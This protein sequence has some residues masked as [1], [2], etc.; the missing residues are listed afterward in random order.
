MWTIGAVSAFNSNNQTLMSFQVDT[1]L[2]NSYRANIEI[3]FQQKG[4]RLR[5][6]VRVESQNSEFDFFDRIGPT[7]AV[8]VKNRHSDTPLISTPHDRRRNATEDY[9]WA[10]LI[11]RKD[12]IRMLA[13]PTSSYV[14][15]AVM[16]LGRS[17]DIEIARAAF[18]TAYTG[19][20]GSTSVSFPATQDVAVNF[21]DITGS[22]NTNLTLSKLR[23]TRLLFDLEEAVD[24]DA[25]E[26]LYMAVTAWQINSMLREDKATSADYAAIKALVRGEIET[27][28]GIKFIRVHPTVLTKSG[29]VRQC[30]VWTRQGLLLGIA[31]DVMVD[32]GPRRDK[33]NSVQAYVCASFGA[34]RMWEE[35]VVRVYCDETK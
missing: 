11:D 12:K 7:A 17:M 28:M 10:D 2:V 34:T 32:V 22:G 29:D 25:A 9:D 33:R 14:T 35:Q 6:Y 23:K 18:A 4:S 20:T 1:A 19:K 8:K 26:E 15:N 13:D 30:P 27:F 31:D 24:W 21:W 16:A 3:K 5:P